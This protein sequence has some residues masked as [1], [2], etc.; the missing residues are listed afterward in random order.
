M[1]SIPSSWPWIVVNGRLLRTPDPDTEV[2]YIAA[3][4]PDHNGS[5]SGSGLPFA[6]EEQAFDSTPTSGTLT[7]GVGGVYTVRI[8]YPNSFYRHLGSDLVAPTLYIAYRSGG[9][10]VTIE[11][12]L[13]PAIPFRTLTY[14]AARHDVSFYDRGSHDELHPDRDVRTQER[15]LRESG[16]PRTEPADFWGLVVPQ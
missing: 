15:I 1:A 5:F 3:S 7:I 13:G 10:P 12:L 16:Y 4:P 14:P 9:T 11:S 2:R 8:M 6:S